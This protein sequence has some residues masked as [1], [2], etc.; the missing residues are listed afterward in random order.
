M[1]GAVP[2]AATVK[3]AVTGCAVIR[4]EGVHEGSE[5]EDRASHQCVVEVEL[6]VDRVLDCGEGGVLG[7]CVFLQ[8]GEVEGR[9][10][11]QSVRGIPVSFHA[12]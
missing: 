2:V 11:C 1:S 3:V 10:Y 12:I 8:G 4:S 9:E 7:G 5:T 6:G